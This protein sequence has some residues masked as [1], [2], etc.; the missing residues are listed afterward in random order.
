[1]KAWRSALS[2]LPLLAVTT[3][4]AG[5]LPD[6]I[7]LTLASEPNPGD[8]TLTWT[9]GPGGPYTV[10]RA[11]GGPPNAGP[12]NA[13]ATT[14]LQA[15]TD[16]PPAGAIFFYKVTAHPF[17]NDDISTAPID[18]QSNAI[19]SSLAAANGGFG[20]G[21]LSIDFSMNVLAADA[22]VPFQWFNPTGTFILPDC[23][24]TT[25]PVP[26]GGAVEGE[27][28][29]S[30]TLGGDCH[31][32]VLHQ[33]TS[34]L[35]EMFGA[36]ITGGVFSGG[37]L[38]V[39]D[40]N[41]I[42]PPSGRGEQCGSAETAGLPIVPLL[43]TADDLRA[44]AITH[45]IRF[46]LP[47]TH[48][49]KGVYV[50]PATHAGLYSGVGMPP[51]GARFRLRADYPLASLPDDG[52]RVIARAMQRYG[53]ILTDAGNIALT[54]ANDRFTAAKWSDVLPSGPAGL[55]GIHVTDFQMTDGGTRI[56]LTFDCARNP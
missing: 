44:G 4:M 15:W 20:G 48:I 31:M 14:S 52:A 27:S 24:L 1:M 23:D 19:I 50:H 49:E 40:L 37:C 35:Y 25:V 13:L 11:T 51:I 17:W 56:P 6:G 10:Y 42:Y 26:P 32:L 46:A 16:T 53:M 22:S 3:A 43:F 45:A 9:A 39:W 36:D 21:R 18:P 33:P 12:A 28:G 30:C 38:A 54:G 41:R 5:D 8:V 47:G 34:K 7:S 2:L 29:Y 55:L